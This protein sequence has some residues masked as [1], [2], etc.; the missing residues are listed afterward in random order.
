MSHRPISLLIADILESIEKIAR[1]TTGLD[2]AA[3]L[4]DEKTTDSV[5]RNRIVHDYFGLDLEI[6]WEILV[7][8]LPALKDRISAIQEGNTE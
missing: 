5:V 7:N 3:F 2:R 6:V 4:G 1:Y 8:E